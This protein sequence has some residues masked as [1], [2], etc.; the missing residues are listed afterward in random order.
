MTSIVG[1]RRTCGIGASKTTVWRMLDNYYLLQLYIPSTMLVIVSWV[2]FW[3]DRTAVPAR[4]T[5]GVTTLLTMT[6]QVDIRAHPER[7]VWIKQ[8]V[9]GYSDASELLVLGHR[10]PSSYIRPV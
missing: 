1:T 2:S 10:R 4:V 3:L 7:E 6:T 5:L 9:N 8:G